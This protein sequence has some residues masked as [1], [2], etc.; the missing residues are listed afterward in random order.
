[1]PIGSQ[2]NLAPRMWSPLQSEFC[3]FLK[4]L[5]IAG[6]KSFAGHSR[7]EFPP[8]ITALV[9]P[10]GSGK[11]N[12]VD[13]VRWCLGEQSMRDLRGQR[14]EDVIYAAPR[15]V[16]G[17]AEVTMTFEPHHLDDARWNETAISRRLYRSGDSAYLLNGGRTRLRDVTAVLYDLG[18]DSGRHVIV[19]QGMADVLLSATPT[20]RRALLEQAAGL[21]EYREHR[22]EARQKLEVISQNTETAEVV[23][24][25]LEPRL[26]LLRRQVKAFQDR[27]EAVQRLESRLVAWYAAQW[28]QSRSALLDTRKEVEEK[29]N[30]RKKNAQRVSALETRS[31]QAFNEEREWHRRLQE[32]VHEA[33]AAERER[34]AAVS[35]HAQLQQSAEV[36][37]AAHREDL[38]RRQSLSLRLGESKNHL[39]IL[40][41][42]LHEF[43]SSRAR[44][45]TDRQAAEGEYRR[46]QT[47]EAEADGAA[48]EAREVLRKLDRESEGITQRIHESHRVAREYGEDAE[49]AERWLSRS[50]SEIEDTRS[51]IESE[52]RRL[53]SLEEAEQQSAVDVRE[54]ERLFD[55]TRRTLA[56]LE[57][58]SAKARAQS[59]VNDLALTIVCQE[60][61]KADQRMGK[62][63]LGGMTVMPGW[64]RAV[65]AAL[66]DW[67]TAGS[68]GGPVLHQPQGQDFLAWR[69]QID[70]LLHG[71]GTWADCIAHACDDQPILPLWGAILVDKDE[72]ASA[73]WDRIVRLP[74]HQIGSP[75][76][77]IVTRSGCSRSGNGVR[78]HSSTDP[79]LHFLTSRRRQGELEARRRTLRHRLEAQENARISCSTETDLHGA[80]LRSAADAHRSAAALSND[81]RDILTGLDRRLFALSAEREERT[82]SLNQVRAYLEITATESCNLEAELHRGQAALAA[83]RDTVRIA[84]AKVNAIKSELRTCAGRLSS[85]THAIEV[86]SA[87]Q[88][89]HQQVI[90][91][92][93]ADTEHVLQDLKAIDERRGRRESDLNAVRAQIAEVESNTSELEHLLNERAKRVETARSN[94]PPEVVDDAELHDARARLSTTIAAHESGLVRLSHLQVEAERLRDEVVAELRQSPDDIPPPNSDIPT[95]EELRRL[96][97]RAM[98]FAGVDQSVLVECRDLEERREQLVVQIADLRAAAGDLRAIMETA[99]REMRIR[100][101][102]AFEAVNAEFSRVFRIMLRGGHATLEQIDADGGIEVQAQLPGR[103]SRSS[104]AFSGGERALVASSLLFGVLR[105][106][107]TPFCILDEVD[108]AL[109]ETNVDRYLEVLRDISHKTQMIVVTHNRAT[110]ACADILYGLTMDSEGASSP[111]SLR[112]ETYAAG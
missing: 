72:D 70:S 62:G 53:E 64:E 105:V 8:G 81:S 18:I 86:A 107:P 83:Q 101:H 71:I 76:I 67:A 31:R 28:S 60:L 65:A 7:F 44:E 34:D 10:N 1:M 69:K 33:H 75:P 41:R 11:S 112:L 74:A 56:R 42:E 21:S 87:R 51:R 88:D 102:A 68:E 108:A 55:G 77:Q 109:D 12:V 3:L 39:E 20:E 66:E 57:R 19:S 35:A 9:G 95:L 59:Q 106:R 82:Q 32:A 30:S 13:A 48:R 47:S 63:I 6:F 90:R 26:R 61:A 46:L 2:P 24:C 38:G 43:T 92:V 73:L 96:R 100:F 52:R 16:L 5:D 103:R 23:L 50:A 97:S 40:S 89:A 110:M 54:A 17:A 15:K 27:D 99:D 45:V 58:V 93:E 78:M 104:S 22:D 37:Q 36:L 91:N 80:S 98:Q 49:A 79:A 29:A 14:A 94:R 85:C 84:D 4:S 25:E 111:L